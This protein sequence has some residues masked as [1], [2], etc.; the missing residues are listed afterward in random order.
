MVG[1]SK[2]IYG[3]EAELFVPDAVMLDVQL[4]VRLIIRPLIRADVEF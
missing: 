3:S 4:D 1:I 2:Y